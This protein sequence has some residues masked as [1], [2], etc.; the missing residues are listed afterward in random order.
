MKL[1]NFIFRIR[2]L[3]LPLV[4]LSLAFTAGYSFLNWLIVARNGW[5]PID[6]DVANIWLPGGLAWILVIF[7][8][9]RR[10]RLLNLR[11]KRNN[12]P[13]LYHVAAVAVVAVPAIIAQSYVRTATGDITHVEDA[14]LIPSNAPSKFYVADNVC[15][16]LNRP[17]SHGFVSTSGKG[18]QTLVFN[19]YVVTPVCSATGTTDQKTVWLG[20]KF[21]QTMSNSASDADKNASYNAF[22]RESLQSFNAEDPRN[23]QFL[24]TLGHNSDRKRYDKVLQL[25]THDLPLHVILVPHRERFENRTGDRLEWLLGSIVFGPLVW[26]AMIFLRPIDRSKI[27]GAPDARGHSKSHSRP[28][29]L[30]FLT[31][32]GNNYG[33]PILLY[34]NIGVFLVMALSG[35]GVLRF[36]SDD[37]L[38][39]GANYRPAI[40]GLGVFRLITSQ[41]V[42]GG[43]IHLVNNL[44]GLLF[45]GLFLVPVVTKWRLIACYLLCG[46][47]GSI[48]NVVVHPATVSVGASG[49]IFGLF[50]ILLTLL[51]LRDGRLEQTRKFIFVNA[52]IFIALNLVIG[53]ATPGIDNAAHLGGLLT[54]VLLAAV[55]FFSH[56]SRG[57]RVATQPASIG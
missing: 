13:I 41:F 53:A 33:L 14:V 10:L 15:M 16:H 7:V 43:L 37:L 39:W 54:G 1:E 34:T 56:R 23:F 26:L 8:F 35:L 11:D 29:W 4:A 30:T 57:P 17:V 40:H 44:Y 45:A 46:L 32:F 31:A 2:N 49:A 9:Q 24:E 48:A 47:G 18:N 36:D 42:H 19:L 28:A 51:L 52:G 55:L 25:E 22:V 12:L 6:E 27:D 20:L 38:A 5:L 3:F 50:G 21:H